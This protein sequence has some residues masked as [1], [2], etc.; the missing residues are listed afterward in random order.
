VRTEEWLPLSKESPTH[1]DRLRLDW[2]P[3]KWWKLVTGREDRHA[4][5]TA[6]NRRYCEMCA[7]TEFARAL[8][9]GD[10]VIVGSEKYA[11]YREQ[12]VTPEEYAASVREYCLQ[13]G[14]PAE[15]GQLLKQL[16]ERLT[17]SAARVDGSFPENEYLRIENG[18]PVLSRLEKQPLPPQLR[19]IGMLLADTLPP[20][21]ILDVLADTESWLNW[22]RFFGPLSGHEDKLDDPVARYVTTVFSYGC[23]LGPSQ[24][25]RSVTGAD[26]RQ[27][28]WINQRHITEEKLDEAITCMINGYN[29]FRLPGLWGSGQNASADGTKWDLYE[30]NLLSEY[31]IRYGGYGGVG[32]YHI[33][34]KYIALF[35]H[36][37]S[38]GVREA[39]YILDGLL[40]N[41]SEIQPDAV[42]SD[43]HGQT[44]VVFGLA[45]LLGIKLMPR[46]RNWKELDFCRPDRKVRYQHIDA[47]FTES[48][49]WELIADSLEE[50]LRM[51]VS[52][53]AGK[54]LPS[55]IL[56]RLSSYS[57]HNRLYQAF[58]ELGQ[59][60]RTDFLLNYINDL[61][62]RRVI[63]GA[64]NKSERFNQ[65]TQWMAF[66]GKGVITENDRI[67]QQ[68]R[69]KYNHLV[70]NCLIFY[71]VYAMTQAL[72]K[73]MRE[74][75][76]IS[77]ETLRHLSPYLTEHV[78][79]FGIYEWNSQRRAP[80][81]NYG[82]QILPSWIRSEG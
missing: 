66:G 3:D 44:A 79:R 23:N 37:I 73:M 14:L 74:G 68:K 70:A 6:I 81:I 29:R 62:L 42:H 18:E 78:N 32:Y 67:E 76:A 45:Y 50:M 35:S 48:V 58:R 59:V 30:Q 19:Q 20:V 69:I 82:L 26:R 65:F 54:L 11:D 77:E 39:T 57:R 24:A 10:L 28:G 8:Q 53:K 40:R 27:I 16:R 46:I 72:H 7:F 71:N 51:A 41:E 22:T 31:H 13:S 55:T 56:R 34:D 36:F 2:V 60:V 1:P 61:E 63:Q 9:N 5:V 75:I 47:L 52:I 33:A 64:M 49:D 80:A 21:N 43:T 12:F 25:A 15:R 4:N 17:E 38:C